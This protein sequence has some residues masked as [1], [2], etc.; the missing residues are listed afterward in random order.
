MHVIAHF[1]NYTDWPEGL[2]QCLFNCLYVRHNISILLRV[3][4][5]AGEGF[6]FSCLNFF[7]VVVLGN[8]NIIR[9]T[10]NNNNKKKL[11][12]KLDKKTVSLQYSISILH[13][14]I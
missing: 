14:Q 1:Q 3:G 11:S 2:L 6:C 8:R 12:G 4:G 5:M 13:V 7:F 10:T 9:K